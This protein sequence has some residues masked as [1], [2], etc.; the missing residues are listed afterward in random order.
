M[1]DTVSRKCMC[2]Y[3]R[4]LLDKAFFHGRATPI[5]MQSDVAAVFFLWFQACSFLAK[6]VSGAYFQW[7][8]CILTNVGPK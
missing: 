6:N 7:G 4:S 2:F 1:W 8:S 5:T 3:K